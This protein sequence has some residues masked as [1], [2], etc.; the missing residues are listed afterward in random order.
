ML[1]KPSH[2]PLEDDSAQA[3]LS[4]SE[5][6]LRRALELV[7]RLEETMDAVIEIFGD[8]MEGERHALNAL[9]TLVHD[10][11][12]FDVRVKLPV[13]PT[14]VEGFVVLEGGRELEVPAE[15]VSQNVGPRMRQQRGMGMRFL[16]MSDAL[17]KQVDELYERALKRA[18]G[19]ASS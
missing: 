16:D 6:A 12:A 7:D 9:S 13:Q 4:G 17:R 1:T 14:D 2:Q 11:F 8:E 18:S 10:P 5:E 19:S 15:V 3:G